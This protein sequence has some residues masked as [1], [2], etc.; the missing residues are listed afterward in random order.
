MDELLQS[1][2]KGPPPPSLTPPLYRK[3]KKK[4]AEGKLK[5]T[6]SFSSNTLN[7][8]VFSFLLSA[9]S[10]AAAPTKQRH[11]QSD[12]AVTACD[13]IVVILLYINRH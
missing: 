8:I 13:L 3:K 2:Q 4:N 5:I 9:E 1:F 7:S 6:M 12:F 10:N 11:S